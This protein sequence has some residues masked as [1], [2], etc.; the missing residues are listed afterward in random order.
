MK[1]ENLYQICLA[2]IFLLT[3]L[4]SSAQI[5]KPRIKE[6]MHFGKSKPINEMKIVLPG[7][8]REEQR[9][10]KN[11]LHFESKKLQ[12]T[13][14]GYTKPKMQEKE[15]TLKCK[16][17]VLNFDGVSNVNNVYPGDPNGDVSHEHFIQSVNSSFAIWDKNGDLIYGPVDYS[18][19]W[20]GFPGPWSSLPMWCDPVF[21]YD[22]LADRWLIVS[23]AFDYSMTTFYTMFAVSDSPNPLGEYNCYGYYFEDLNDYPKLSVWPNGYY[24]TYNMWDI[25][26]GAF[27]YPLAT[28]LDRDAM[29][30]G[31]PNAT[32]IEFVITD[33][34]SEFYFPLP[35]DY[36]GSG[37]SSELPCYITNVNNHDAGNPWNLSLDVYAFDPDWDTPINSTFEQISQLEIGAVEPIISFSQGAPQLNNPKT[38]I[39]IPVYLMYPLSYRAFDDYETMVC[40]HTLW[41]GDVHY[42]KWYELRKDIA[43]WYVYQTGNYAPD[44]THRFQ[45]SISI[46]GN[47]D[48][49]LGFSASDASIFPSIRMTGRRAD[50]PLG[51]MTFQEV[52]LFTGL[53]YINTYQAE[54]DA[55]R[56]GDYA[57][58]MVDPSDDTTF[59]FTNMYSKAE[60]NLGNWGTRIF[61]INLEEELETVS[62][63]AGN[64]TIIC[65]DEFIFITNATAQNYNSLLWTSSGDGTFLVNNSLEA[66]YIRGN[67]DIENGQVT[68][69]LQANGYETGS[70]VTDSLTLFINQ[71]PA[72]DAGDDDT[73]WIGQSYTLQGEVEFSDS[74]IWSTSGDGEFNDP[75]ILNA[76]YTPGS[77]DISNGEVDLTLTAFPLLACQ[78]EDADEMTLSILAYTGIPLSDQDKLRI[79]ASPNPANGVVNISSNIGSNKQVNLEVLNSAGKVIFQGIFQTNNGQFSRQLDISLIKNGIYYIRLTTKST[80]QTTKLIKL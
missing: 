62:A 2:G 37:A 34:D 19:L 24:I 36:Y 79:K 65:E 11:K 16:G 43:D 28:V 9:I 72:A 68:L 67:G 13:S 40:S 35:A 14:T 21:K 4:F 22:R 10:I 32:V 57:S 5:N 56:W 25:T 8:H 1:K 70:Y 74:I 33:A 48:I 49:A 73:I 39:T 50:D 27:L 30:A 29:L 47:G 20:D 69:T 59:W 46:N 77:N 44:S 6:A 53:N 58:M 18:S 80:S 60:T 52:E 78:Y 3:A 31:E 54:F 17:P 26:S 64:D 12:N 76:I 61:K 38:I 42:I 63:N 71:H 75:A 66:K 23:I 51:E 7:D 15:G 45:P 41:D 55:N